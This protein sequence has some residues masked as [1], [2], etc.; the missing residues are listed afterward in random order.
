MKGEKPE[1]SCQFPLKEC[2]LSKT[3]YKPKV[4][5]SLGKNVNVSTIPKRKERESETSAVKKGINK[6]YVK[7]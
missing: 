3:K 5:Q 6:Y 4:N 2:Y 1:F 7:R